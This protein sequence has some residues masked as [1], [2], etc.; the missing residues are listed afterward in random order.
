MESLT[1]RPEL[2]NTRKSHRSD[3]TGWLG[4]EDSNSQMSLP[5]LAFQVRPE[6]PCHFGTFADQR[7]FPAELKDRNRFR[8]RGRRSRRTG[9]A[10]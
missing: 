3:R 7:L 10:R 8:H 5:K 4:M 2:E 1:P 9:V 6:F